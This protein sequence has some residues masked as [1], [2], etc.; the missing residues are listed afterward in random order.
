MKSFLFFSS[1]VALLL[2][3]VAGF[4]TA[5]QLGRTPGSKRI[6]IDFSTTPIEV[7]GD[8]AFVAPDFAAGDQRGPCPGLNALANHGYIRRDGVTTLVEVVSA[9]NR[10]Y[11]MGLDVGGILSTLGTVLVGNPV[12][13]SPGFSIGTADPGS[14]DALGNLLGLLGT[15]RGLNGSHN[16]IECDASG[17]RADLYVTGDAS[18]MDLARFRT[19]YDDFAGGLDVDAFDAFAARSAVRF[20]ESLMTN[21]DFYYGPW[22][23]FIAR[24]AGYFFASRLFANYSSESPQ[25]GIS[26]SYTYLVV[27]GK[28]NR[29]TLLRLD[30]LS[31]AQ[32]ILKSFYAV[33]G[34]GENMTY[35]MGHERIPE[36][37]YRA[38]L[39]YDLPSFNLDLLSLITRYP[40]LAR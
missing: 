28:T 9:M 13:T 16:I 26:K 11:G 5:P 4:P 29:N 40:E 33:E 25:G 34:D 38:P 2:S 31:I 27:V 1:S 30:S 10:V 20:N 21:P 22:S 39:D 24:S 37:W 35:T 15:P 14:Q 32:D 12:S 8:H 7:T 6:L 18:T 17:T 23:G 3:T 19:L 36:N